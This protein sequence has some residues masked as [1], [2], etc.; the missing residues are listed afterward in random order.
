MALMTH[1]NESLYLCGLHI[2]PTLDDINYCIN[3]MNIYIIVTS[4]LHHCYIIV[5]SLL[6]AFSIHTLKISIKIGC[7][8][9]S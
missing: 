8:I 1:E 6:Q 9:C 2:T 3:V 4:L 7:Y 5:T